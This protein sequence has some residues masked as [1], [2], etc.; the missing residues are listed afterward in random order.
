[1]IFRRNLLSSLALATLVVFAFGSS[2]SPEHKAERKAKAAAKAAEKEAESQ[3]AEAAIVEA[4]ASST[5]STDIVIKV[6]VNRRKGNGKHWDFGKGKPDP[7]VVVSNKRTGRVMTGGPE[8]DSL[9]LGTKLEGMKVNDSDEIR[10][11]VY[12]HDAAASDEVG[13]CTVFYESGDS[14]YCDLDD[15][16]IEV[17]FR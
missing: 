13:S 10:F 6:E 3:A 14:E 1:M 2:E 15:G 7:K 8:D 4:E 5:D 11:E 16:W 9:N 17:K 12:D